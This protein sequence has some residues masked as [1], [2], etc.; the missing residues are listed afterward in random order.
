MPYR[1]LLTGNAKKIGSQMAGELKRNVEG[2]NSV[3]FK[4]LE[5]KNVSVKVT[6]KMFVLISS[7][8]VE[9]EFDIVLPIRMIFSNKDFKFNY[10]VSMTQP[11]GDPAEFVRNV[12]MIQDILERSEIVSKTAKSFKDINDKIARFLN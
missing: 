3:G 2:L 5:P 1:Y 4:G 11:I 12:S 9:C 6:P 10:T 7:F 8:Q